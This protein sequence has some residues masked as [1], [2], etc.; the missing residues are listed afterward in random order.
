MIDDSYTVVP[1]AS[2]LE[3]P[4]A[5]RVREDYDNMVSTYRKVQKENHVYE[6]NDPTGSH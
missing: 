5:W 2:Y 6:E 3:N 1:V 4:G